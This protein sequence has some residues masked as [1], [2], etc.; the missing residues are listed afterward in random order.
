MIV[1]KS[2]ADKLLKIELSLKAYQK[3]HADEISELWKAL[4]DCKKSLVEHT[5]AVDDKDLVP[6]PQK[7]S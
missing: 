7:G 2:I 5:P 1:Q 6:P 3:L 4:D